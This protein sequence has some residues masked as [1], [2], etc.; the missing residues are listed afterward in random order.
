MITS[1][2]VPRKDGKE[3][4]FWR[5]LSIFSPHCFSASSFFSFGLGLISGSPFI[6]SGAN[7][8]IFEIFREK[9]CSSWM[10]HN[11][12]I[13]EGNMKARGSVSSFGRNPPS[14]L[15]LGSSLRHFRWNVPSS[16]Q[17]RQTRSSIVKSPIFLIH[18]SQSTIV[19][20]RIGQPHP[21]THPHLLKPN[22]SKY[23][24]TQSSASLWQQN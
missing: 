3:K 7:L 14:D 24:E 10:G 2:C 23:L 5:V 22:E 18:R 16:D 1:L 9:N 13:Q 11:L 19:Q 8:D 4:T 12:K 17:F 20:H 6:S 21:F 15:H